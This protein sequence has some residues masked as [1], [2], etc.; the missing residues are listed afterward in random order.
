MLKID[1][2]SI[3]SFSCLLLSL[4]GKLSKLPTFTVESC[5]DYKTLRTTYCEFEFAFILSLIKRKN[6]SQYFGKPFCCGDPV[7]S[8][9]AEV[10]LGLAERVHVSN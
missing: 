7:V 1:V 10:F 2:N 9:E 6:S 8:S 5:K 4:N 3:Q